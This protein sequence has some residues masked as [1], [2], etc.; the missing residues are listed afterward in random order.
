MKTII[1]SVLIGL[2]LSSCTP[3]DQCGTVTG[4]GSDR[5]GNYTI[6]IDGTTHDVDA[7]TWLKLE[8]GDVACIEY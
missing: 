6:D 3:E 8:I 2:A 7:Y 4:W 1:I 5:Y